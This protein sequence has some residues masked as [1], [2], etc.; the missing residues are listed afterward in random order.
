MPHDAVE[1]FGA[2]MKMVGSVVGRQRERLSIER[3]TCLGDPVRVWS[4]HGAEMRRVIAHVI[5]RRV[6]AEH[7]VVQRAGAVRH[8]QRQNDR[9]VG[10][11]PQLDAVTVGDREE[12]DGGAVWKRTE[13]R[14]SGPRR[15]G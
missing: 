10:H 12:F 11:R 8:L 15:R 2:A 13:R 9:A 1:P 6:V 3:E 5:H 7:D 14:A 4:D